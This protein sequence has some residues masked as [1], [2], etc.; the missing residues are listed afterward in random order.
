MMNNTDVKE[1]IFTITSNYSGHVDI[2]PIEERIT[3]LRNVIQDLNDKT[4][5]CLESFETHLKRTSEQGTHLEEQNTK[6]R[7]ELSAMKDSFLYFNEIE[8][9][10]KDTI[11]DS[12]NERN[13]YRQKFIQQEIEITNLRESNRQLQTILDK[14]RQQNTAEFMEIQQKNY[15][16]MMTAMGFMTGEDEEDNN[17]PKPVDSGVDPQEGHPQ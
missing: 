2:M 10:D 5:H 7:N 15:V 14:Y 6:L 4:K 3:M 1:C 11:E 16:S 12:L 8:D 17:K 9:M 13:K